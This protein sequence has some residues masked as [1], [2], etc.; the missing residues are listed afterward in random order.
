MPRRAKP[1]CGHENTLPAR[2]EGI[3][4][5]LLGLKDL[6]GLG[7]GRLARVATTPAALPPAA[8]HHAPVALRAA[9]AAGIEALGHTAKTST[10]CDVLLETLLSLLG[11]PDS[12]SPS[13]LAERGDAA[14]R[15]AL[16][17]LRRRAGREA[18]VRQR[19]QDHD[20]VVLDRDLY[21][22]EPAV[23]ESSGKPTFYRTELFFI[24][25]YNITQ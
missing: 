5:R 23:W 17:L 19:P 3:H 24:H 15:G 14:G 4:R 6:R 20:L 9:T 12:V 18:Y 1:S 10:P 25:D 21:S 13:L 16:L 11:D 8:D 2:G 7:A 22:R